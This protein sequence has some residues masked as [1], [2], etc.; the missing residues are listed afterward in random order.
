MYD[1][2]SQQKVRK[3]VKTLEKLDYIFI[4]SNRL[5]DSIPR[6]PMRFPMTVKYYQYLFSGNLGFDLVKVFT[7]YPTLFGISL[8]DDFAE[9]AYSVYDHPKVLIFK[10]NETFDID[11]VKKL[12]SHV[13]WNSI[14]KL[15]P[16]DASKE[17]Y[18]IPRI[19]IGYLHPSIEEPTSFALSTTEPL[20]LPT[21]KPVNLFD[22]AF[23]KW[24][25]FFDQPRGVAADSK[26]NIYVTDF[27]NH[28]IQKFDSTG[29]FIK[30]WGGLGSFEGELK[31]P[32]GIRINQ[33]DQVFV[34]DTWNH[35]V[36]VFN[37]DGDFLKIIGENAGFFGPRDLAISD[38]GHV[39]V[40]DTGNRRVAIFSPE[41]SL[42]KYFS[43]PSPE[44]SKTFVPFGLEVLKDTLFVNDI[45]GFK[46]HAFDLTGDYKNSID[47]KPYFNQKSLEMYLTISNSGNIYVTS[48]TENILIQ[49][50]LDGRLIKKY[51]TGK[52][53]QFAYPTG[54]SFT[55]DGKLL[56]VDTHHHKVQ[57]V[58]NV[59][60][61]G[62]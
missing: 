27:R 40:S 42:L 22:S 9:E 17:D 48:A 56:V 50:N 23:G 33:K 6:L 4:T 44:E 20:E 45:D 24:E 14:R 38:D 39:F 30:A 57:Y 61:M 36:Q 59:T 21:P 10:K 49:L 7:S 31:E 51:S 35:R 34:S 53:G 62:N 5:Y 32:T 1:E 2:D 55:P 54:L 25:S 58:E 37:S 19:E 11:R 47:L 3:V 52:T 60:Q 28:R 8:V 16:I 29:T 26:G 41:G 13:D 12:L 46:I 15:R 18:E 43:P